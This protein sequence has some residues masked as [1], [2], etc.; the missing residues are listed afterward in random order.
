VNRN[1]P[2][3]SSRIG[4]IS[5]THNLLR[6]QAQQALAGVERIIHAGDI[7]TREVLDALSAIAP[8]SAVRGNNDHG[9]WANA[10][11]ATDVITAEGVRI[12]IVHDLATLEIDPRAEAIDVVVSGHSHR[13]LIEEREGVLYVNPGAAGPRRFRLPISLGFLEIR[14]GQVH[15]QLQELPAI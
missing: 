1:R 9:D 12:L 6:E 15:A 3:T 8:V 14:G 13:P 7:C 11:P 10:L 4:L 2:I 5:D